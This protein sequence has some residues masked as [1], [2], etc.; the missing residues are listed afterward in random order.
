MPLDGRDHA[1]KDANAADTAKRGRHSQAGDL[2]KYFLA[3]N[4]HD[5]PSIL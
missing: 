3:F 5:V 2:R 4:I 1:G